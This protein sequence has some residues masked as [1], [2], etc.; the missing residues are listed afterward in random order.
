MYRSL[1]SDGADSKTMARFYLAMIQAKLLY[2]SKTWVLS[3]RLLDHLEHFHAQC[4]RYIAHRHICHLPDNTWEYPPT[5]EVLDACSLSTIETY[6]AKRKTTL[7][8][9]YA[10]SLIVHC[11]VAASRQLQS[12]VALITKCGGISFI[13]A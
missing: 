7:L 12:G 13:T 8:N 3:R 6:I 4:A 11:T 10:H 2:G 9:H 5:L 1:S